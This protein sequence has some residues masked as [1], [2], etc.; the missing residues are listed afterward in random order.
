MGDWRA[1][2]DRPDSTRGVETLETRAEAGNEYPVF[3]FLAQDIDE[4]W[5]VFDA[6]LAF[7]LAAVVP[8]GT[9][10]EP[11]EDITGLPVCCAL[12]GWIERIEP[13]WPAGVDDAVFLALVLYLADL[14]HGPHAGSDDIAVAR[15]TMQEAGDIGFDGAAR[16]HRITDALAVG[17]GVVMGDLAP[18]ARWIGRRKVGIG[19]LRPDRR[20]QQKKC[21]DK[22]AHGAML[23]PVLPV[24]QSADHTHGLCDWVPSA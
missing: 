19:S 7:V 18:D 14:G 9:S 15:L 22:A 2:T 3:A 17:G 21:N 5:G 6:D 23:A 16:R 20:C 13:G 1:G 24:E 12:G 10:H 11:D 8:A 4:E